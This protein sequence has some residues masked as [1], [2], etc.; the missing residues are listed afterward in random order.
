MLFL[1]KALELWKLVVGLVDGLLLKR[2]WTLAYCLMIDEEWSFEGD[3][4]FEL[5][6]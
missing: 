4:Q 6:N 2:E 3:L 1:P 5:G